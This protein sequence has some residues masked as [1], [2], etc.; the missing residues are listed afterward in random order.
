MKYKVLKPI[1]FER[2]HYVPQGTPCPKQVASGSDGKLISTNNTGVIELP[3][4]VAAKLTEGQIPF[5]KDKPDPI[6]AEEQRLKKAGAVADLAAAQEAQ[7]KEE[8]EKA[9]GKK[10]K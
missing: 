8:L 3:D 10:K 4:D 1:E 6:G 7:D 2:V 9:Q 5:Y